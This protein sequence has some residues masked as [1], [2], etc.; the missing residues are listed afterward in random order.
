V[1]LVPV[2]MRGRQRSQERPNAMLTN[3]AH[4][5]VSFCPYPRKLIVGP[6]DTVLF[7]SIQQGVLHVT[8]PSEFLEFRRKGRVVLHPT[9]FVPGTD[10]LL[11]MGESG[12]ERKGKRRKTSPSLSPS[13]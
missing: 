5:L 11:I 13:F 8:A 1:F 4:K 3:H 7:H 9:K 2:N 10:E 12:A 6:F